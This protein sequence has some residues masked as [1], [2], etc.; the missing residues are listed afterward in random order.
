MTNIYLYYFYYFNSFLT[1]CFLRTHFITVNFLRYNL[2]FWYRLMFLKVY[3]HMLLRTCCAH[4][5]TIS[6]KNLICVIPIVYLVTASGRKQM[7]Y[8]S[9]KLHYFRRSL[10]GVSNTL[11]TRLRYAASRQ[12]CKLQVYY[13][14]YTI[15]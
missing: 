14:N 5:F 9:I 2:K 11:P 6:T 13:G 12:N 10:T 7:L 3:L 8:S 15:I 1:I 4:R